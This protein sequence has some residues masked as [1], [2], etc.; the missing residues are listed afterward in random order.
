MYVRLLSLTPWLFVVAGQAGKP[1]MGILPIDLWPK[2]R[3]LS[4]RA[5]GTVKKEN[6][7]LQAVSVRR[8]T[9]ATLVGTCAPRAFSR[10]ASLRC[11]EF[12]GIILSRASLLGLVAGHYHRHP[13]VRQPAD[14]VKPKIDKARFR[15]QARQRLAAPKFDMPAV[16][17]RVRVRIP[18]ASL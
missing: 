13:Q 7:L 16:P 15:E 18:L 17:E 8:S 5:T 6:R 12:S 3:G 14:T 9:R 11:L 10:G 4:P 2:A 1:A